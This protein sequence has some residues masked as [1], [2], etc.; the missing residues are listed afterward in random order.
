MQYVCTISLSKRPTITFRCKAPSQP[1]SQTSRPL[2]QHD[3][4]IPDT[5][6]VEPE[7]DEQSDWDTGEVEDKEW[8]N[9][10][11][12][13]DARPGRRVRWRVQKS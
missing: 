12:M 13:N 9:E 8:T 2:L 11:L 1:D 10:E 7:A 6:V 3:T 4:E 5:S